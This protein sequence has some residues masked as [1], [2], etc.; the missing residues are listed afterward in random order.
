MPVCSPSSRFS[1]HAACQNVQR[2]GDV[3][4]RSFTSTG[5]PVP[6]AHPDNDACLSLSCGHF[7]SG[8][9]FSSLREMSLGRGWVLCFLGQV[10]WLMV[11]IVVGAIGLCSQPVVWVSSTLLFPRDPHCWVAQCF[12]LIILSSGD[13]SPHILGPIQQT[14]QPLPRVPC[15]PACLQLPELIGLFQHVTF[16]KKS[17][18]SVSENYVGCGYLFCNNTIDSESCAHDVSKENYLVSLQC[19][20]I[21]LYYMGLQR[22]ASVWFEVIHL[23]VEYL[24]A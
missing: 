18:C 24:P 8:S 21:F 4:A 1:M 23:N 11:P 9:G 19:I 17:K 12:H 14:G 16:L 7:W 3:S 13:L 15:L 22:D 2:R 6:S 20:I 5:I 10:S